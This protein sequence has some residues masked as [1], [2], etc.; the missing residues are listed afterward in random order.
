MV[1]NLLDNAI[2][3]SGAGSIIEIHKEVGPSNRLKLTVRDH[4][5]GITADLLPRVFSKYPSRT[6]DKT[7]VSH[8]SGLGL[9]FCKMAV[10]SHSGEIVVESEAGQGTSVWFTLQLA[11][12]Q[13]QTTVFTD[14]HPEQVKMEKEFPLTEE[15]IMLL[16]PYCGRLRNLSIH[17]ISD[18]KEILLAIDTNHFAGLNAWKS[19]LL[20]ALYDC[21]PVRYN[22]LIKITENSHG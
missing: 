13:V 12:Y 8:S 7:R 21:N 2:K 9:T 17:Q 22:E 16:V 19:S 11:K 5:E 3:H 1:I 14:D 15:E 20:K 10:E 6:A 4:G 18:V